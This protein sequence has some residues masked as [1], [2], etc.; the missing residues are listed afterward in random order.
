MSRVSQMYAKKI[1][2]IKTPAVASKLNRAGLD[3]IIKVLRDEREGQTV[4][5]EQAERIIR[6][7][8]IQ[9][10]YR[11]KKSG[12]GSD[13]VATYWKVR[14][15]RAKRVKSEGRPPGKKK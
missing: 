3:A 4:S 11:H 12:S 10:V 9:T 15:R 2:T 7:S 13:S 8:P 1:R 5:R 6:N 14:V